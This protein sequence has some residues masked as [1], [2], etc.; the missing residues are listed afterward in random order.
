MGRAPGAN[1]GRPLGLAAASGSVF[2]LRPRQKTTGH[3][4]T[5]TAKNAAHG[6]ALTEQSLL[7]TVLFIVIWVALLYG[8]IRWVLRKEKRGKGG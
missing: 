1:S 3:T 4:P 5:G 6:G 8:G 2:R 7:Q